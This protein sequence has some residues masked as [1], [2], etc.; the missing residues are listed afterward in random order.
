MS[1]LLAGTA[2]SWSAL[3][4]LVRRA[5]QFVAWPVGL[6]VA[7]ELVFGRSHYSHP[8]GIPF[9]AGVSSGILVNGAILG[10][11]YA[12]LAFGLILVYRANRII[13]FAHAGLGLVPGG[14]GVTARH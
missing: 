11:L 9:P 1:E 13:N 14:Y 8:L 5:I 3:P 10:M 4:P 12:F 6:I 7:V 2:R